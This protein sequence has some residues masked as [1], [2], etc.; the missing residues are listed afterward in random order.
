[1]SYK[2]SLWNPEFPLPK[3]ADR[4]TLA[5]II[6]HHFFPISHRTLQTW[7]LTVRR[8]NRASIYNVEEAMAYAE[9]K[10]SSAYSYKQAD[11]QND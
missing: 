8:P 2:M 1:M 9:S 6:T 7:P 3:H 5:A 11:G 4:K 10:L